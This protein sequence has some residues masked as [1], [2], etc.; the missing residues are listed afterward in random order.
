MRIIKSMR[1]T[2]IVSVLSFVLVFQTFHPTVNPTIAKEM[3]DEE[4]LTSAIEFWEAHGFD[5]SVE[6]NKEAIQKTVTSDL[7]KAL[8]FHITQEE[9]DILKFRD[10]I[11]SS[12]YKFREE[13]SE[14]YRNTYG[15]ISY[16]AKN[17]NVEVYMTDLNSQLTGEVS[18]HY[19]YPSNLI[20]KQVDFTYN[21]LEEVKSKLKNNVNKLKTLNIASFSLKESENK[22]V[23]NVKEGKT[24][25]KKK[26]GE[27]ID[28]KYVEFGNQKISL[29]N[30]DV[31]LGKRIKGYYPALDAYSPCSSGFFAVDKDNYIALVTAGHCSES[32]Y[33]QS[34]WYNGVHADSYYIGPFAYKVTSNAGQTQYSDAGVIRLTKDV[35]MINKVNSYS[36]KYVNETDE[37]EGQIIYRKGY[38]SG[39]DSG[40][41]GGG[42]CILDYPDSDVDGY[43]CDLAILDN[44]ESLGGDSGGIVFNYNSLGSAY[45]YG[46]VTSQLDRDGNGTF[47]ATTYSRI[48]HV[49]Q[50]LGLIKI[51]TE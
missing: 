16:D 14:T 25:D 10:N 50:E 12:A 38:V 44:L 15:G 48:K 47:D 5:T 4:L 19:Q 51:Y 9:L 36:V 39:T 18:K 26:I 29:I 27:I 33:G 23:L 31:D 40:T 32:L 30:K 6:Y 45:L 41:Y 42:M 24:P 11:L 7:G 35:N 1:I 13:I 34:Y 43:V 46:I 2:M 20:F 37:M 21:E 17:G 28:L 22:I 49:K 3:V 8:G